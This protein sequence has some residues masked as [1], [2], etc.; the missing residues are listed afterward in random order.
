LWDAEGKPG[1]VLEGLAESVHA[2]AWSPDSKQLV[3][4]GSDGNAALWDIQEGALLDILEGGHGDVDAISWSPDGKKIAVGGDGVWSLWSGDGEKLSEQ[5]GHID[6]VMGLA[7]SPNGQFI[8]SAG[9]D[10]SVRLWSA[11]GKFLRS[12]HGHTAPAYSASWSPDSNTVVSGGRDGAIRTWSVE[13]GNQIWSAFYQQ[14]DTMVTMSAAGQIRVGD[15]KTAEAG[16]RY[17]VE[18]PNGAMEV[19]KYSEFLKRIESGA[20]E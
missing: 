17:L 2:I 13:S 6:A 12:F 8:V 10:N 9:W 3:S 5:T 14:D 11:E 4:G 20:T 16:L 7:F 19:L 15:E 1:P 18:K